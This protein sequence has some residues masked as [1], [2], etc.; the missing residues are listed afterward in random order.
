MV[1]KI[2]WYNVVQFSLVCFVKYKLQI[3]LNR[4][5]LLEN[6]PNSSEPNVIFYGFRFGSIWLT[7]F[8]CAGLVQLA[9]FNLVR[10]DKSY[11]EFYMFDFFQS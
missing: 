2:L 9:V 7:I 4:A 5:V 8:Y 6:D 11:T 1:F 3:K 10:F